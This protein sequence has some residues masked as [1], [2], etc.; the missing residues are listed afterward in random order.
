MSV[1]H[2]IL[3]FAEKANFKLIQLKKEDQKRDPSLTFEDANLLALGDKLSSEEEGKNSIKV[4]KWGLTFFLYIFTSSFMSFC[5]KWCE[6]FKERMGYTFKNVKA[7]MG[8]FEKVFS[9]AKKKSAF[10]RQ[11]NL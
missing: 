1:L 11:L 10:H 2:P 4:A 5:D 9:Y 3:G 8:I 7:L 6:N